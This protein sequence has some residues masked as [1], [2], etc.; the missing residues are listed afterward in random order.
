MTVAVRPVE[1]AEHAAVGAVVLGAYDEVGRMSPSYRRELADTAAR[2]GEHSTVLVAVDAGEVL[3][4]VTVVA[5]CSDHFEHPGAGDGGFR[6]LAVAPAAQGRGIG[7]AL[8]RR[9]LDDGARDGWRRATI[10]TMEWMAG[11]QR[12]YEQLGFERRAD[13][14]VRFPTGVGYAY[15]CDL[16]PDASAAFPAPG[17]VPP[18][19]PWYE[20]AWR[21]RPDARPC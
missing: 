14:D 10:T 7:R 17:P 3:G 21:D 11:A 5:A 16:V 15:A 4:T 1:P 19:P 20:D 6:A 12:L 13:L 18:T 2:V 8:V 9:A